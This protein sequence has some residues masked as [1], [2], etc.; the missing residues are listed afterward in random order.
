VS[1]KCHG[2]KVETLE[3]LAG[4]DLLVSKPADAVRERGPFLF[5]CHIHPD[6]QRNA[7]NDDQTSVCTRLHRQD[8]PA[9]LSH[10]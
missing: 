5:L 10:T 6:N 3:R 2:E 9:G 8:L 4:Q 7:G 1:V